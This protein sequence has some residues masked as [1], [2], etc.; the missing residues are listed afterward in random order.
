MK[1]FCQSDT[2]HI[3][4]WDDLNTPKLQY[5][6]TGFWKSLVEGDAGSW[7]GTLTQSPDTDSAN[8]F[9]VQKSPLHH[10]PPFLSALQRRSSYCEKV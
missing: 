5:D 9:K 6:S 2:K 1:E 10:Y 3:L 4:D 8:I 7:L